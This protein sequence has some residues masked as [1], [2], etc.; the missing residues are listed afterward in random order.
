MLANQ[1]GKPW[2]MSIIFTKFRKAIQILQ[3]K[4]SL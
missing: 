2:I 4:I 1:Q 3:H